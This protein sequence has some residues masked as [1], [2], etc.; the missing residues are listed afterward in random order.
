MGDRAYH[1]RVIEV[2]NVILVLVKCLLLDA[3]SEHVELAANLV[4]LIL[5]ANDLEP[6]VLA[7]VGKLGMILYLWSELFANQTGIERT[8]KSHVGQV[9][10]NLLDHFRSVR[11]Q[12]SDVKLGQRR[13]C[14]GWQGDDGTQQVECI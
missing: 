2:Q 1:E 5:T 14:G 7:V 8:D 9:I 11:P 6:V 10:N 13:H 3:A 12:G 4:C